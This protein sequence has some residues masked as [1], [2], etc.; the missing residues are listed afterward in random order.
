MGTEDNRHVGKANTAPNV[1]GFT[2]RQADR[3]TNSSDTEAEAGRGTG[4]GRGN[5]SGFV[6]TAEATGNTSE[7]SFTKEK[8]VTVAILTDEEKRAERNR[9]R[10]ERY[11]QQKAEQGGTVKPRKVNSTTANNKTAPIINNSQVGTIINTVSGIVAS[12]PNMAHWQLTPQEVDSIA[13]PLTNILAKS[14]AFK[15]LEEHGDS[16]ALVTACLTIV[17]PR[18]ILTVATMEK[19]P[20]EKTIVPIKKEKKQNGVVNDNR[21][22]RQHE[23]PKREDNVTHDRDSRHV[24]EHGTNYDSS[25]S[26]FG[27]ALA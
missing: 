17:V 25:E 11:A 18:I 12:R 4:T 8:P 3:S 19:K 14:E 21:T 22:N 7:T 5:E 23:A 10:R 9:K 20:K 2:I 1:T 16:V 24:T 27:S 26:V 6:G 15:G 13:T